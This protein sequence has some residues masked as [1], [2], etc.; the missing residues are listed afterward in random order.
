VGPGPGVGVGHWE[1]RALPAVSQQWAQRPGFKGSVVAAT[2]A[3]ELPLGA[4]TIGWSP[5]QRREAAAAAAAAAHG[6]QLL[7]SA[8]FQQPRSVLVMMARPPDAAARNPPSLGRT[9]IRRR[10]VLT[11]RGMERWEIG[12][13]ASK[14]GQ[15]YYN[16]S[17]RR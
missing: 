14:I 3:P 4:H 10:E 1:E 12:D 6:W 7:G 2:P 8:A 17:Q 16:V 5:W 15:L 9:Q 11:S 13:I